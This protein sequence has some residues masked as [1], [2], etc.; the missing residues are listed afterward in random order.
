MKW[1]IILSI[2]VLAGCSNVF[3][4]EEITYGDG[5]GYTYDIPDHGFET[6]EEVL[7]FVEDRISYEND[8]SGVGVRDYWK[9]PAETYY[10]GKGD[11]EDFTILAMYLI[12][13]ELG[14]EGN[15]IIGVN[16]DSGH[17]W[18]EVNGVWWEPQKG[19]RNVDRQGFDRWPNRERVSYGEAMY[20]GQVTKNSI[21]SVD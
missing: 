1:L 12:Y 14:I 17:A 8:P 2:A 3:G 21:A 11:C 5:T 16:E 15:M 19:G 4:P 10:S 7:F 9:N 18:L 13:Q 6:V 20:R